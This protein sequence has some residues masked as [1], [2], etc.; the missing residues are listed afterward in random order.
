ADPDPDAVEAGPARV[1]AVL[2]ERRDADRHQARRE[3]GGPDVPLLERS[4]PEVLDHDVRGGG[5][6]AEQLLTFGLAQVE[7]DAL[8][9]APLDR[10]EQRVARSVGAV[11]AGNERSDLAHEVAGS[12][13]LDLHDLR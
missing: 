12:G 2:P 8:A 1:R 9:P 13:L 5:E 6:P 3:V 10:P 11:V 7:C 4:R